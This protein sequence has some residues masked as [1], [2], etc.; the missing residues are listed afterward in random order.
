MLRGLEDV[1]RLLP[2][3]LELESM[4][5]EASKPRPRRSRCTTAVLVPSGLVPAGLVHPD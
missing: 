4:V 3:F 1:A 5:L 2:D